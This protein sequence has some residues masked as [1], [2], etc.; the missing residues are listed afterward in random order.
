[1]EILRP[2]FAKIRRL[3]L[4]RPR[5]VATVPTAANRD[6]RFALEE[7][8]RR[9]GAAAVILAPEPLAAAVFQD[10][11]GAVVQG[12]RRMAESMAAPGAWPCAS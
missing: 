1:V 11:L 3:G 10:P 2:L 7:T 6:E 8:V 9:A 4:V 12:G 5:V